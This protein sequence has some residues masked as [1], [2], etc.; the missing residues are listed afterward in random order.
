LMTFSADKILYFK[1]WF[2]VI[3]F[4]NSKFELFKQSNM[5]I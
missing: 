1:I 5:K 4:W 2:E 3:I